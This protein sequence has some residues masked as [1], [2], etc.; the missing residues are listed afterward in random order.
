MIQTD[1]YKDFNTAPI[2]A[3]WPISPLFTDFYYFLADFLFFADFR[4]ILVDFP[5]F[6]PAF[7]MPIL[8]LR[9]DPESSPNEPSQ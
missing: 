1:E 3:H 7:K 5:L 9:H 2:S 4:S 6:E 8:R